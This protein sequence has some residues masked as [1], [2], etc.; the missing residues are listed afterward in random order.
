MF[1][2]VIKETFKKITELTDETNSHDLI[3]YFKNMS[4]KRFNDFNN[5]S[6]LFKD[7]EDSKLN[8]E[9]A[10]INHNV[11]DQSKQNKYEV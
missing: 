9:E 11:L 1:Y 2:K 6:K 4:R 10:K 8:P 7:T 3:C 5:A